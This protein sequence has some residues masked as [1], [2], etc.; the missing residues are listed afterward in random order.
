[1]GFSLAAATAIIGVAVLI[2]LELI[3]GTTIPTITEIH[4]SYDEM[5]DRAIDQL[6][7]DMAITNVNTPPN[8]SNY[9]LNIT[10]ENTGSTTLKTQYFDIFING[11][12]YDY[13]CY[14][15]Y[16]YPTKQVYFNVKNLEGTG[17][18]ILKM[19]TNNGISKYYEYIIS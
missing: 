1:M 5:R 2:S 3:I 13:E 7:T 14:R 11:T 4:K 15:D 9:D 17:N 6:Q 12:K 19:V 8:G 18:R 16:I 10:V